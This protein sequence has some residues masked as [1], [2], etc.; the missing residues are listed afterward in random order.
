MSYQT[1]M[2]I[3]KLKPLE[4]QSINRGIPII[5]TEKGEWLL[6]IIKEYQ[7]QNVLEL[8]TANGYSGIILGSE[9]AKLTTIELD[10]KIAQEAQDNF[11]QFGINATIIV[12]NAVEEI[13]KLNQQFDLIFID[14]AKKKY[15]EILEDSIRLLKPQGIIIADNIT[16]PGCQDFKEAILNHKQ[17]K[18][19]II[20]IKD[21]LSFSLKAHTAPLSAEKQ[22]HL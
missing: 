11:K 5:G 19:K 15:I 21:K 16:M 20:N 4:Q 12:G 14:F 8:G 10:A 17:L 1:L 2:I 7:P 9:G 13:K 22:W 18:T 6:S 3:N